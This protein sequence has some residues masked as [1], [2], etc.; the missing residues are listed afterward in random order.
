[1]QGAKG[2][3]PPYLQTHIM[4]VILNFIIRLTHDSKQI[5]MKPVI[6]SDATQTSNIPYIPGKS[7][8]VLKHN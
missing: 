2:G 3:M 1:M 6:G 7:P 5:Y 4:M 8:S